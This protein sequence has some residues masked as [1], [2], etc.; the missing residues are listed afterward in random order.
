M[1]QNIE[2]MWDCLKGVLSK[3]IK[4]TIGERHVWRREGIDKIHS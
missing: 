3:N 2:Y 1:F 4:K